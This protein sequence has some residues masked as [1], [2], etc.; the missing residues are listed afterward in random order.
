MN[1]GLLTRSMARLES[2]GVTHSVNPPRGLL[3]ER[4]I[5]RVGPGLVMTSRTRDRRWPLG[6]FLYWPTPLAHDRMG[7]ILRFG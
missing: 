1:P 6:L 5:R 2:Q 3:C 4:G 7:E